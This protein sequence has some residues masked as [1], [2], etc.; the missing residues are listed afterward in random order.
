MTDR[1][2]PE[3]PIPTGSASTQ[4]SGSSSTQK[5]PQVDQRGRHRVTRAVEGQQYVDIF[6]PAPWF[7]SVL[8]LQPTGPGALREEQ[9]HPPPWQSPCHESQSTRRRLVQP[10]CVVDDAQQRGRG[11]DEERRRHPDRERIGVL[12]DR[13]QCPGMVRRQLPEHL[14]ERGTQLPQSRVRPRFGRAHLDHP[15][16]ARSRDDVA[17]QRGLPYAWVAP[18]HERAVAVPHVLIEQVDFGGTAVQSDVGYYTGRVRVGHGVDVRGSR[19]ASNPGRPGHD[20]GT[21][22]NPGEPGDI[23]ERCVPGAA[24]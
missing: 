14:F 23:G 12:R 4:A 7:S 11:R 2:A 19:A 3:A 10:L 6:L 22:A 15:I 20:P 17:Q 21:R 9:H 5:Q 8:L 16:P 18:Q 24:R 13:T 1:N